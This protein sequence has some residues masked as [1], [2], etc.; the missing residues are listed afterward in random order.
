VRVKG[1]RKGQEKKGPCLNA[2]AGDRGVRDHRASSGAAAA[3]VDTCAMHLRCVCVCARAGARVRA[4]VDVQVQ[5][6]VCVRTEQERV[7]NIGQITAP[8]A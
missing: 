8:H 6:Q 1:E 3:E 5:V 4:C 2:S 7:V